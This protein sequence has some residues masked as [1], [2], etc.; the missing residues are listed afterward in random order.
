MDSYNRK[1]P[2]KNSVVDNEVARL[3]KKN[4]GV[5]DSTEFIKL[6]N[7]YDNQELV[8]KIQTAYMEAYSR[9]VRRAKKFAHYIREKYAN[10]GQPYSA[11]LE[12][13]RAFKNKAGLSDVE[14]DEFKRIYEA[15]LAGNNTSDNILPSTLMMKTLGALPTGLTTA[16]MNVSPQDSGEME[17]ILK[18][19]AMNRP[20]HAQVLL[21]SIQY[22]DCDVEAINGE[23]NKLVNMK[24]GEHIHPVIAALFL[25]KFQYI[26]ETFLHSNIGGIVKSR[27]NDEA[28]ISKSDYEL[29]YHMT[30]DPNDVVCSTK[31]PISDLKQRATVQHQLLNSVLNLRNGQYYNESFREFIT[32]VDTCKLNKHDNPDLIYGRYDGTIMKRLLAAFSFR[33]TVVTTFS[34]M[35]TYPQN[36][37]NVNNTPQV[38]SIQMIN[39]KLPAQFTDDGVTIDLDNALT[40]TQYFIEGGYIVPKRTEIIYSRGVLIFYIDRRANVMK[41]PGTRPLNFNA[42]PTALAGFERLNNRQINFSNNKKIRD[43]DYVLRSVVLSEVNSSTDAANVVIGSSTIIKFASQVGSDDSR[44]AIQYNPS[45]VVDYV[46]NLSKSLAPVVAIPIDSSELGFDSMASTRG[47][48]FIYQNTSDKFNGEIHT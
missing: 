4:K 46:S 26:D 19:H 22:G 10:S 29:F 43:D 25:P 44:I 40:Q 21:Q 38:M 24:P 11:L 34:Q 9:T 14:F 48:I 3:L 13:A 7:K 15:D 36:P 28:L 33:P 1:T 23:Y 2:S 45:A 20:L 16:K 37:Y 17:H 42:F 12:K 18:D 6:R 31:S 41:I 27:Y 32:A 35:L 30:M 39:M 5:F 8:E 47:C